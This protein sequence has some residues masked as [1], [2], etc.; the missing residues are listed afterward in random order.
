VS[1]LALGT[2]RGC[3]PW[4][5]N[6]QQQSYQNPV[7]DQIFPDPDVLRIDGTYYAYGTYHPWTEGEGPERELIPILRSPNLVDWEPVG[8]AFEEIPPWSQY[9]GLWAPGV[10]QLDDRIVLYCSDSEFGS[11]DPGIGVA[12]ASDPTGPFQPRGGLFRSGEIGV[13]NSID[14][15]LV[16]RD[17]TPYLFWGSHRGIYGVELAEDGLSVEGDGSEQKFQIV[18]RGV[19][20]AYVVERGD[21]FYFFGSRGSCC[22]GL[23]STYRVVVGR[24]EEFRGPYRNR[25]GERLTAEGATGT[26]ILRGDD[27]F[28]GPGHCSVIRDIEGGWWM[29]YHAYERGKGWVGD[30]PRRVLM[31]DRIRWEDGWPVVGDGTPSESGTVPPLEG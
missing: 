27:R 16:V 28:L 24:A 21:H 29:F 12:S 17:G 9:R 31:L 14:P 30:T 3:T 11:D 6:G 22:R 1:G 19:E 5:N 26:V 23:R 25:K 13:R 20:A 15:A 8:P 7:Y 4:R 10:G 18:G 2:A